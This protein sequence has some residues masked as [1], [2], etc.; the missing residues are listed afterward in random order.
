VKFRTTDRIF[1][2]YN[3]GEF[4][5]KN[6]KQFNYSVISERLST[7]INGDLHALFGASR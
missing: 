3:F 6:V 2:K 4:F 1:M 5:E 7:S